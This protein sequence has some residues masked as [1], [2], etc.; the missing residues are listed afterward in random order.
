MKGKKGAIHILIIIAIVVM[1]LIGVVSLVLIAGGN[2]DKPYVASQKNGK[3]LFQAYMGNNIRAY[4]FQIDG[5][6][7]H[8]EIEACPNERWETAYK[9]GI[10]GVTD[11]FDDDIG[12]EFKILTV[13]FPDEYLCYLFQ[14]V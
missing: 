1:A 4:D 2:K 12:K 13:K 7:K 9:N 14:E 11:L 8:V 10:S 5:S 3:L 6:K